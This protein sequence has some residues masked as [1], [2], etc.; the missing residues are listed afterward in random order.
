MKYSK[1]MECKGESGRKEEENRDLLFFFF[2]FLDVESLMNHLTQTLGLSF[3][4]VR[5]L[6]LNICNKGE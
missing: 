2:F 6:R 3:S 1:E 5:E 4:S